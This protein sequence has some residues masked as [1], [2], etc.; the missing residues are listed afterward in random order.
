MSN[1]SDFLG[2]GIS[3]IS[4]LSNVTV[5]ASDPA[6]D[7]NP[8][9]VGGLW[10]NKT[11]GEMYTCTDATAGENVWTN[12]GDG[13]GAID[14]PVWTGDRALFIGGYVTSGVGSYI[15]YLSISTLGNTS[16]FGNLSTLSYFVTSCSDG[17]RFIAAGGRYTDDSAYLDVAEYVTF[18]TLGSATDFGNLTVARA[19]SGDA[20]FSDGTK[21]VFGGGTTGNDGASGQHDTIDYITIATTGNAT[22]FGNLLA[23]NTGLAGVSDGTKGLWGGGRNGSSVVNTIQY[24]TIASTVNATDFGDLTVARSRVASAGSETRGLFAAGA[25]PYYNTIDYITM[26]SSGNAT[27]FGDLYSTTGQ[28]GG[29]SN[30][31]RG[32]FS[33]WS[34]GRIDYV[35]IATTGNAA[36]FGDL[37]RDV[38]QSISSGD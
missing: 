23:A 8:S 30:L 21:G 37:S 24:I 6:A 19:F 18:G 27:D 22:D 7:T 13:A 34:S 38:N 16:S 1:L 14:P 4:D 29:G 25:S 28:I 12:V 5:S 2:S 31:T 20:G 36:D 10:L 17:S 35:A 26:S 33:G 15:D 9:A 3:T 32:L 11:S